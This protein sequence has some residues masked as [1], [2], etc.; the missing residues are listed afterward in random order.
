MQQNNATDQIATILT[1][2]CCFINNEKKVTQQMVCLRI[3]NKRI[4]VSPFGKGKRLISFTSLLKSSSGTGFRNS[5]KKLFLPQKPDLIYDVMSS[6]NPERVLT[7]VYTKPILHH[8]QL[9]L[10]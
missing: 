4:S 5:R 8:T 6:Y 3:C 1:K 7:S 9:V 2:A 10:Y